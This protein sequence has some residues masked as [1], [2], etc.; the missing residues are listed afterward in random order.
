MLHV[1]DK[2]YNVIHEHLSLGY[3]NLDF[4]YIFEKLLNKF[5]GNII[6]EVIKD[7]KS[8]LQSKILLEETLN[9]V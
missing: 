8:I 7:K 2:H 5:R 3:G 1:A 9:V 6:L 4:N